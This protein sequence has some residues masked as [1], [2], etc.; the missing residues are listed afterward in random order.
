MLNPTC[1]TCAHRVST[2]GEKPRTCW[3]TGLPAVMGQPCRIDKWVARA[4]KLPF[5][6]RLRRGPVKG[7]EVEL[8]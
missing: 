5:T 1:G 7:I 8:L 4:R 2:S 6:D 3:H